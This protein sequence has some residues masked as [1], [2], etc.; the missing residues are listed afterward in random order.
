MPAANISL[1]D[2][3]FSLPPLEQSVSL[4]AKLPVTGRSLE[5]L[6]CKTSSARY[7]WAISGYF[8]TCRSLQFKVHLFGNGRIF[9]FV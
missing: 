4:S 2:K 7:L 6:K 9:Q 3:S 5:G 1:H 8:C